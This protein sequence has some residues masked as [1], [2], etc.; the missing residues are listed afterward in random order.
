MPRLIIK[1]KPKPKSKAK[2]ISLAIAKD[3][4][5]QKNV[6]ALPKESILKS[7]QATQERVRKICPRG[8]DADG[9]YKREILTA[10]LA[11]RLNR[12]VSND[13]WNMTITE[14][15]TQIDELNAYEKKPSDTLIAYQDLLVLAKLNVHQTSGRLQKK[16]LSALHHNKNDYA[17]IYSL[18]GGIKG[19]THKRAKDYM[20]GFKSL[21]LVECNSK[22]HWRLSHRAYSSK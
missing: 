13:F 9:N 1:P 16:I 10:Y 21:D 22:G 2:T 6:K 20:L 15:L 8:I 5:L 17:S 3:I 11:N 12:P 19:G 18:I 4:E 7:I 14:W